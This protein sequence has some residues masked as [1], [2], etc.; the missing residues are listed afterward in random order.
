MSLAGQS[1][2]NYEGSAQGTISLKQAIVASCN[3]VFYN[4]GYQMWQKDGGLHPEGE[5][6]ETMAETARELGFGSPT[7][8]DLPYET[9]GRIPDREWKRTF[10]EET[11][12]V[13][14]ER[15]EKGYPDVEDP[16]AAAYMKQLAHE[17]CVEGFEWRANKAINFAIGQGDVL[18]S[19]LQLATAYSSIANGGTVYEPRVVRALAEADGSGME[20]IEPTVKGELSADDETLSYLQDAL[21]EVTKSGTGRGAFAGFPQDQ[22]SVAGKTGSADA[23]GREVS[24]WFA[25]YAPADDPQYAVAVMVSQGGTGG[26]TAA[27]IASEIYKGIYG[28]EPT[29]DSEEVEQ[30]EPVLPDGVP[31]AELPTIRDDGSIETLEP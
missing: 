31:H 25:S 22:V 28:F 10:W 15:A 4:F 13:N 14:C 12:E 2:E 26:E 21:T 18:V 20:E 19:P 24:S 27:P 11:R 6:D 9:G 29:E 17:H 30:G 8:I 7:G 3:T 1:Y 23:Q 16:S 5:P